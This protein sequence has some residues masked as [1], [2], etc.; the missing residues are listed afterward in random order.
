M[1]AYSKYNNTL[2]NT[3]VTEIDGVECLTKNGVVIAKVGD[4]FKDSN[5]K[6]LTLSFINL[7]FMRFN[8]STAV[9]EHQTAHFLENELGLKKQ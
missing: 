6:E 8:N 7:H 1:S 9:V 3:K 2:D 5:D 4:V